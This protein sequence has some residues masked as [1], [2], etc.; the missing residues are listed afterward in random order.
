LSS[1]ARGERTK[2]KRGVENRSSIVRE[3]IIMSDDELPFFLTVA[4]R[5][6]LR[7]DGESEEQKLAREKR[8]WSL[9]EEVLNNKLIRDGVLQCLNPH[10]LSD[11]QSVLR[12]RE[13]YG[14][15]PDVDLK[16]CYFERAWGFQKSDFVLAG[17]REMSVEAMKEAVRDAHPWINGRPF[18]PP[19]KVDVDTL[20]TKE[21]I[22]RAFWELTYVPAMVYGNAVASAHVLRLVEAGKVGADPHMVIEYLGWACCADLDASVIRGLAGKCGRGDINE[23]APLAAGGGHTDLVDLLAVE[24]GADID[25]GCLNL[26]AA[27]GQDAMIDRLVERY[28]LDPNALDGDGSTALHRAAIN[29][30]TRTVQHLVEKHSV[31]IHARNRY[32]DTAL[33][34]AEEHGRTE[35]ASFLRELGATNGEPI[36]PESSSDEDMDSDDD[37]GWDDRTDDDAM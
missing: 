3:Q 1:W 2:G 31:D 20:N 7:L 25:V 18:Y 17:W 36:D 23:V 33:D 27:M 15:L 30:R 34:W 10:K 12:L 5:C 37:S 9:G 24:F 29:G 32:G 14:L 6:G 21:D 19:C 28:G 8:E 11:L 4:D 26:A 22:V 13:F 16:E 35:C